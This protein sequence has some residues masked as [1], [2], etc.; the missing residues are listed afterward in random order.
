[1][2]RGFLIDATQA[3]IGFAAYFGMAE[4]S[5]SVLTLIITALTA[6][7]RFMRVLRERKAETLTQR[8]DVQPGAD[9]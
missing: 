3:G 4:H 5:L 1:M 2:I 9:I 6:G 8:I 7:V